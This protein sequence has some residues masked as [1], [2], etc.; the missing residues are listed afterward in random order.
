MFEWRPELG[1]VGEKTDRTKNLFHQAAFF[2]L[3]LKP[4]SYCRFKYFNVYV[5]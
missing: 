1:S 2:I 4:K 3:S 5:F